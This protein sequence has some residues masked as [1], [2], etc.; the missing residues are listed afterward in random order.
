MLPLV[1]EIDWSSFVNDY[2]SQVSGILS[3]NAVI[4][5]N[6]VFVRHIDWHS[7]AHL[8]INLKYL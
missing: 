3:W 5:I 8:Y 6:G 1:L 2:L 7:I 4:N